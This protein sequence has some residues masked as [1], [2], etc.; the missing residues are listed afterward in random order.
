MFSEAD[1]TIA[2]PVGGARRLVLQEVGSDSQS[3][4]LEKRLVRSCRTLWNKVR[5]SDF[6][7]NALGRN[8]SFKQK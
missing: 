6:I 1:W 3:E 4:Q 5:R 7:L 8:Q 2:Q